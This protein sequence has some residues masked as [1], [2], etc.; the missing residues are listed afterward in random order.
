MAQQGEKG[1]EPATQPQV[2]DN[3]DPTGIGPPPPGAET[4]VT[5]EGEGITHAA[6][7]EEAEDESPPGPSGRP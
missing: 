2:P 3:S 5:A 6:S 7:L 1:R 4:T